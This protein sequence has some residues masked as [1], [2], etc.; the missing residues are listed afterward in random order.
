MLLGVLAL[1][2]I[3]IPVIFIFY[4]FVFPSWIA[5]FIYYTTIG[6]TGLAAYLLVKKFKIYKTK[7]VINKTDLT[8]ILKKRE[9]LET[10]INATVPNI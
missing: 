4:Y 9:A 7:G 1:G 3:N 6:M 10:A 5:A 8:G 2:I